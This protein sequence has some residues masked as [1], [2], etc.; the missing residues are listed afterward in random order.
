M[1]HSS[2]ARA[3]FSIGI[4]SVSVLSFLLWLIYIK[5]GN[6]YIVHWSAWLPAVNSLLN[7]I[8]AILLLAGIRA[9]KGGK[10]NVHIRCMLA[11][12]TT[13]GLFL[14]SYIVYH[15][16]Q[17]DTKF[18]AT[19]PI[20]YIYFFILISH[21]I[22]SIP[23]VPMVLLTLYHAAKGQHERHKKIARKTLPIWLYVCATGVLIYVFLKIFN[24]SNSF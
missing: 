23:L 11:A 19:G 8:T 14:V 7:A 13:S 18:L 24:D 5:Q 9:I 6:S 4:L 20:R 3:Y 10:I 16:F 17:G 2:D 22:L 21:I 15:Y 12:V 1:N